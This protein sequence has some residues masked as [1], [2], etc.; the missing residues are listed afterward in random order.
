MQM[1]GTHHADSGAERLTS[2]ATGGAGQQSNAACLHVGLFE[3]FTEVSPD[4]VMFF[5]DNTKLMVREHP[6]E[7]HPS[8][9][10][11]RGLHA[12]VTQNLGGKLLGAIIIG[13]DTDSEPFRQGDGR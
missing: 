13:L 12:R 9:D 4:A 5:D 2:L 8:E 7:E 3:T 11:W 10:M 1:R 6:M